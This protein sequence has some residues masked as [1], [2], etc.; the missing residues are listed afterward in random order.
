MRTIDTYTE[1]RN[2]IHKNISANRSLHRLLIIEDSLLQARMLQDLFSENNYNSEVANSGQIAISMIE[3]GRFDL[4]LMDMVLPDTSGLHLLHQLK[5][6]SISHN[7]P[8]IIISGVTD[9]ENI[10]EALSLGVN[11]Y[12]TKPYHKKELLMRVKLHLD[13]LRTQQELQEL[14]FTKDTLFA[15]LAHDLKNPFSAMLGMIE[16]L[17]KNKDEIKQTYYISS[18]ESSAKTTYELFDNLILWISTQ[19]RGVDMHPEPLNLKELTEEVCD[20]VAQQAASK[21]IILTNETDAD[22][23]LF[24]DFTMISAVLRN[25]I[26]NAI[27]FTPHQGIVAIH[28][29]YVIYEE[30]PMIE[31]SIQDTGIGL[32]PEQVSGII[33]NGKIESCIGTEGEKG[34]GLGLSICNE[35]INRNKGAIAIESKPGKGSTFKI[36]LPA[37]LKPSISPH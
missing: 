26:S 1:K 7:I 30:T 5:N 32:S 12:I 37:I 8:I 24:G 10:V 31:V 33:Q 22:H 17:K 15:M 6:N 21:K 28:S 9:K 16:L 20:F 3:T 34:T 2:F 4:I 14:N 18:I 29:N 19:L 13:M 27:K 11:D 35:F 36:Y 23:D 25:L